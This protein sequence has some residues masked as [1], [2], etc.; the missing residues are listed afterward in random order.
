MK[1]CAIKP[2]TSDLPN[3]A[4][5]KGQREVVR[6]MSPAQLARI[7]GCSQRTIREYCKRKLIPEAFLTQGGHWL[8]RLP[9]SPKTLV[10][11]GRLRGDWWFGPWKKEVE[12]EIE[13]DWAEMLLLAQFC[14]MDV[15]EFVATSHLPGVI[16]PHESECVSVPDD[17]GHAEGPDEQDLDIIKKR[18]TANRIR[19]AIN[20][21][22]QKRQ[23]LSDWILAGQVYQFWRKKD[24][25][26]TVAEIANLMGIS[27]DTF[28]RRGHTPE[29]IA[30]AYLTASGELT[31]DLP[32]LRGLDSV[33]RANR[34]AK[35]STFESLQRDHYG[36]D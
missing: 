28:N 27:R 7:Q 10:V 9:L 35:K 20:E 13:S 16:E 30:R 22:V 4:S 31:R 34:K 33:Q 11:L 3:G 5:A 23:F 29:E 36:D 32:D 1:K 15:D 2:K 26:P 21:R 12:G 14:E 8:I 17:S 25:C 18:E 19:S 6:C 24:R